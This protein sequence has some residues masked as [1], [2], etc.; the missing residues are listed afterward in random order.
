MY[1]SGKTLSVVHERDLRLTRAV[2][3][4][5]LQDSPGLDIAYPTVAAD[6][7][8]RGL[9]DNPPHI[10]HVMFTFLFLLGVGNAE[11]IVLPI[12]TLVRRAHLLQTNYLH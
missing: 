8:L 7:I 12:F 5:R 10:A 1:Q 11:G 2:V 4:A 6:L 3:L 9:A